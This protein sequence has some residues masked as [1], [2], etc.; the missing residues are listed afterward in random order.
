MKRFS[1]ARFGLPIA[2]VAALAVAAAVTTSPAAAAKQQPASAS[3]ACN[4]FA[5]SLSP[6]TKL[7]GGGGSTLARGDVAREPGSSDTAEE[8]PG[9]A[10]NHGS[11]FTG[12]IDVY[13]HSITDGSTGAVSD[14]DIAKQIQV[15]NNGFSGQ[16]GGVNTGFTFVLAGI[17]RT[18]NAEW[19]YAGPTTSGERAMKQTLHRGDASDLNIYL[20]TAG[21]YLGWAYFPSNYK[22]KPWID[23]IVIDWASLYKT[24]KDYRGAY[25]LGKTATHETGHWLGLYHVFQGGCNN[26]GDYVDDTPAQSVATFGCPEGQDTCKEPGLDPI[27]NYMDYSFDSCYDQFTAG[28]AARMQDAWLYWRA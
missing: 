27:H 21:A 16:E 25:D 14:A 23:G 11:S 24:S 15:L 18:N 8:V 13:V 2:V 7:L 4:V 20:T 17:D 5:T 6:V 9:Y 19:F 28:Q 22:T 12:R 10:R 3:T 26:W 1:R